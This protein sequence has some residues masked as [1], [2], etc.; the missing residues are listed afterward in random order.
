[1]GERAGYQVRG[2][3]GHVVGW[4]PWLA[5]SST[6]T[7]ATPATPDGGGAGGAHRTAH[8]ATEERGIPRVRSIKERASSRGPARGGRGGTAAESGFGHLATSC[9]EGIALLSGSFSFFLS[10]LPSCALC[11]PELSGA[12][13][14]LLSGRDISRHVTSRVHH[15]HARTCDAINQ[16]QAPVRAA[17]VTD[18]E[19]RSSSFLRP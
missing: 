14:V 18:V 17:R 2:V 5:C 1:M 15:H 4:L 9:R 8:I 11:P 16:N 13:R 6:P 3:K 7:T 12:P 10:P 19:R